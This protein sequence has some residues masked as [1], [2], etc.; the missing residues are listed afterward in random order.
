MRLPERIGVHWKTE[1][2][3]GFEDRERTEATTRARGVYFAKVVKFSQEGPD[4][5]EF[6]E[7]R[8]HME[9]NKFY[10]SH[11]DIIYY[12]GKGDLY[13]IVDRDGGNKLIYANSDMRPR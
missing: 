11:A 1:T 13:S 5:F 8:G 9:V 7:Y 12:L 6:F 3:I 2:F 10:L 4:V